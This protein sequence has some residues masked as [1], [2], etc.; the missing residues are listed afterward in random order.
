MAEAIAVIPARYASVR[1][2]GKVLADRTGKPLVQHVYEQVAAARHVGRVVVAADDR[3]IVDAVEGFG[4]EAVMTRPDHANGTSRIAEVAPALGAGIIVNVQA[5]EPEIE[6]ELI[7][8]AV[9]DLHEHPACVASTLAAPFT[10]AEDPADPNIVKVVISAAGTALYFSRA[11][12][13]HDRD[14]TAT[15]RPLKHVGMYVYRREFLETFVGLAPTPLERAERLEQL[16]ILEHGYAIAVAVADVRF[17]GID[18]PQQYDEFV[19]RFSL[20]AF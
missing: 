1:F 20:R 10:D 5:D 4:G 2:P 7:D 14:G 19:E 15:T 18:T 11:L 12:I 16:R 17:H 6:P 9:Q 8:L 13:P 3:R